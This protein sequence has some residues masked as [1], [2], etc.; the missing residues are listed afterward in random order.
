MTETQARTN[1]D[2]RYPT[3]VAAIEAYPLDTDL[4][5]HDGRDG[6][7]YAL[8]H[9][10]R[11][12]WEWCT[13]DASVEEIASLV[14]DMFAIPLDQARADTSDLLEALVESGVLAWPGATDAELGARVAG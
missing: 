7:S 11:A 8:N 14:A 1:L 6:Q 4:V 3:R 9:T 2:S 5:L 12:I 13:G 10:G